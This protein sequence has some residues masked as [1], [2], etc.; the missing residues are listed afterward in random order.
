MQ[1]LNVSLQWEEAAFFFR[2]ASLILREVMVLLPYILSYILI[3]V[4]LLD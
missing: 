2:F 1:S 3:E 4:N